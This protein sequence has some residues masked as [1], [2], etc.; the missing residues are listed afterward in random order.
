MDDRLSI[1]SAARDDAAREALRS[2][3][4][5]HTFAQLDVHVARAEG[6][7]AA[8]GFGGATRVAIDASNR[9]ETF[10]TIQAL[11]ARGIP[12]VPI[13]PRLTV[14]ERAAQIAD[15]DV[16]ATLDDGAIDELLRDDANERAFPDR[17]DSEQP[18]ATLYTSGTSGR[19]KGAVLQRR[20][21]VASAHASALNLGWRD[22]DRWLLCMPLCHVGGL[23]ILTRCL[24]ARRAVVLQPRFDPDAVIRAIERDGVTLLSVVPT[25]LRALLEHD[26]S[27]VIARS[28]AMLVG[29][30]ACSFDLLEESARRGIHALTTYGLTEACSQVTVQSLGDIPTARRGSG[31]PVNGTEIEIVGE[32]GGV[33]E[34]GHVGRIRVRGATVMRGYHGHAPIENGWIDT[35]DLGELAADGTLH[36]HSRRTDLIV[37]GGENVY[38]VEVEQTLE[39]IDGV[40]AALVFGVPDPHW[41]H[42]VAAAIVMDRMALVDEAALFGAITARLASHKRPRRVCFTGELPM[43]PSGKADRHAA[44]ERFA[45]T[46]RPWRRDG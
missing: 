4:G 41:G 12:F 46:L 19:A 18:L 36:V 13:H 11:I 29:G 16:T 21:F 15:A 9:F 33:C 20:A 35:G 45:S 42:V 5:T 2:E 38:P 28:R 24:I 31:R 34:A 1:A 43:R 27:N 37:T 39:T 23:S 30:A 17:I 3:R 8:R 22:D 14:S 7:L 25:M 32:A 40:R 26:R 6:V 44:V 10:V